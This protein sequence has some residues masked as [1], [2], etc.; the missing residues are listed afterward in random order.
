MIA[1][2]SLFAACTIASSF[3]A[4]R[5][6]KLSEPADEEIADHLIRRAQEKAEYEVWYQ[7]QY[8]LHELE[9]DRRKQRYVL[10]ALAMLVLPIAGAIVLGLL[11]IA[12]IW[13][14]LMAGA[15]AGLAFAVCFFGMLV[16][17]EITTT[18]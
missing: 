13:D 7:E 14:I 4:A 9:R 6:W 16:V 11:L 1:G 15:V 3:W 2:F 8:K 10:M 18:K 12:L 5:K 17:R